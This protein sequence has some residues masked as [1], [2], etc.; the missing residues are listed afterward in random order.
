MVNFISNFIE[1]LSKMIIA[2]VEF[3]YE[4]AIEEMDKEK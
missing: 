4:E 2:L 3:D 1:T